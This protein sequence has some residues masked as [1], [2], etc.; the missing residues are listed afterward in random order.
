MRGGPGSAVSAAGSAFEMAPPRPGNLLSAEGESPGDVA[1]NPSTDLLAL[2]TGFRLELR[3]LRSRHDESA[4]SFEVDSGIGAVLVDWGLQWAEDQLDIPT[5]TARDEA[6]RLRLDWTESKQ[7]RDLVGDFD[8]VLDRVRV[9]LSPKFRR[10]LPLA[11][12]YH[13]TYLA[14]KI[15]QLETTLS[16]LEDR[17]RA[18]IA[19]GKKLPVGV[20]R[21]VKSRHT[22]PP[23]AGFWVP[24]TLADW[25]ALVSGLAFILSLAVPAIVKAGESTLPLAAALVSGAV[26]LG[27]GAVLA[28][29]RATGP[30]KS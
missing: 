29:R 26:L 6:Q 20:Q 21:S 3:A 23:M 7:Y 16:I 13:A 11:G 1:I 18:W 17:A 22:P 27:S 15:G 5:S 19:S 8:R 4:R 25:V 12:V 9:E 2:L 30:R 28:W 10:T 14:T 24:R